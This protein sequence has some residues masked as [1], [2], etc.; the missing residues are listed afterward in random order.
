MEKTQLQSQSLREAMIV[1]MSANA[2]PILAQKQHSNTWVAEQMAR[3]VDTFISQ[4]EPNALIPVHV[5]HPLNEGVLQRISQDNGTLI[6]TVP[7]DP[8][9]FFPYEDDGRENCI[10]EALIKEGHGNFA[11]DSWKIVGFKD[12]SKGRTVYL[13]VKGIYTHAKPASPRGR[14]SNEQAQ[15]MDH[16]HHNQLSSVMNNKHG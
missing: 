4:Y 13:E 9:D 11:L 3:F 6:R 10:N 15:K 1:A 7:I 2:L 12:N 14:I 16:E 8:D 5:P